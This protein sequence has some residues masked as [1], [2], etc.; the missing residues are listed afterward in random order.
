MSA[1]DNNADDSDSSDGVPEIGLDALRPEALAALLSVKQ[2]RATAAADAT[3]LPDDFGMSQFWYTDEC[4]DELAAAVRGRGRVAVVSCPTAHRALRRAGDGESVLFEFDARCGAGLG[5]RFCR[6]DFTEDFRIKIPAR[7]ENAFD[8]VVLDPPYVSRDCLAAFWSFAAWL[9]RGAA[10]KVV[11]GGASGGGWTQVVNLDFIASRVPGADV[12]AW[13]DS[14][15]HF[16]VASYGDFTAGVMDEQPL[17]SKEGADVLVSFV[18]ESCRAALGDDWL[19]AA[20]GRSQLTYSAPITRPAAAD[21]SRR[22]R[23]S[24]SGGISWWPAA[25]SV[26]ETSFTLAFSCRR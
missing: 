22:M 18:D 8:V 21:S 12:R 24:S 11:V 16:D 25:P 13:I 7:F 5:D 19:G 17:I 20:S 1:L 3:A 2:A 4:A 15:L 6:Y 9:S 26:R 23:R 14:G 10:A